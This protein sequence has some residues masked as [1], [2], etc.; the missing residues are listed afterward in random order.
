MAIP[1]I[2]SDTFV[3]AWDFLLTLTNIVTPS[4]KAGH[5]VPEGHAGAGGKWPEY[6]PPGEDDSR[7]AC[8][9]LNALANHGENFEKNRLFSSLIVPHL[10]FRY[11]ATRWK[12]YI[13]QG[14]E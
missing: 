7:S 2:F 4:I 11:L 14:D 3:F 5:V 8:P 10:T 6:V 13:F 12:E 1:K 9:M